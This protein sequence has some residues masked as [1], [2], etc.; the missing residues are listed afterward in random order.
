MGEN[1]RHR[2][3]IARFKKTRAIM[4]ANKRAHAKALRLATRNQQRALATLDA[5][6]NAKIRKSEKSIAANAAQIKLNAKKARDELDAAN[7]RFNA[8]MFATRQEAAKGRSKLAATAASM[9]KKMRA[10]IS[11]K[12]QAEAMSVASRFAKVRATMAKDRANADKAVKDMSTKLAGALNAQKLLQDQRFA[13]TVKSIDSA[14]KEADAAIKKAQTYFKTKMLHLSET[15]KAQVTKL[16]KHRAELQGTVTKNKLAQ[17]EVNRHVSAE[18]KRMIK[19]GNEHEAILSKKDKAMN[20]LIAKNKSKNR[21]AMTQMANSFNAALSK[22]RKQMKAD[23]AHAEHNL[24]AGTAALY[25]TMLK[26]AQAQAKIKMKLDAADNLRK[27]KRMFTAKLAGLHATIVKNDKKADRKV[28]HLAGIVDAD[29]VKSKNG[30]EALRDLQKANKPA[31]ET[32]IRNAVAAGEQRALQVEKN[33]K[34][35]DALNMKISAEIG[36]LTKEIHASVED[37]RLSTKSARAAM[38]RE[39][40]GAVRDSAKE[41]KKNLAAAVKQ[42]NKRMFELNTSFERAQAKG[43]TARANIQAS[44]KKE[45]AHAIRQIQ[46]AVKN[47]NKAL[48]ALKTLTAKRIAKTNARVDAYGAAIE[49]HARAVGAQMK[50]NMLSLDNKLDSAVKATKAKLKKA[51][52][53]SVKRKLAA[54]AAIKTG[55]AKAEKASNKKFTKAYMQMGKDRA[56]AANNLKGASLKL[57]KVMAKNSALYDAA[58]R[59]TVKDIKAARKEAAAELKKA[60][61]EFTTEIVSV[62]AVVKNQET[63]LQGQI[64][65][66]STEIQDNKVQQ[67]KVN[68]KVDAELRRVLKLSDTNNEEG[69]KARGAIRHI[70]TMHKQEAKQERDALAAKAKKDLRKTRSTMAKLRR[71]AAIDLSKASKKLSNALAAQVRQQQAAMDK[72]KAALSKAKINSAQALKRA[73]QEFVAKMTTLTN[74][75]TANQAKFERKLKRVTG[76]AQDFKK[77]SVADRVLL[78]KQIKGM[79]NDL[80]KAIVKAIDIGEAQATR[81]QER[82][83]RNIDATGT[84]LLGEMSERMEAMADDVFAATQENRAQIADNYLALKAY[85]G[86]NAGRIIDYVGKGKGRALFS[87]GDLLMTVGALSK[88]RTKVAQGPGFGGS[89]VNAIFG[90]GVHKVSRKLTKTNGLVNEWSN[91]ITMVRQRWPYGLGRYLL[92]KVQFAMQKQGIL[93]IGALETKVG[94]FVYVNAH[95]IGLSNRLEDFDKLAVRLVD[96]QGTLSKLTAKLPKHKTKI[97]SKK[98]MVYFKLPKPWEGQ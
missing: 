52:A 8:K 26:N 58:F 11:G 13:K 64:E 77:A 92:T 15:V 66:V 74:V 38:K 54:L 57:Q 95:A 16:N 82:A 32:S 17:Q 86:T 34:N 1:R 78:R 23:R 43:A 49:K 6:T 84:A 89:K 80:N 91:V 75:V 14:R 72:N 3:D 45:K 83:M 4:R 60:R 93:G 42:A 20:K 76:V 90:G 39:I 94:K 53:A 28:K 33:A 69:R 30:R 19:L 68:R 56:A 24:K 44:I 51:N 85:T 88:V 67:A 37:L 55:V 61:K 27:A 97:H 35:R 2:A 40:L 9:D 21:K 50:K 36:K 25:A 22:I 48:L 59:N 47:Q 10:M 18:L 7:K 70:I 96:Y 29:A 12:V 62:V 98:K 31:M 41:A 5:E 46:Y 73:K 79:E 65:I 81:V 71:D 87:L 63:K